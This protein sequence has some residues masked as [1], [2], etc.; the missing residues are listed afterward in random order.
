MAD[1]TE[2]RTSRKKRR[3]M[4]V[5]DEPDINSMLKI[6]LEDN[7][8]GVD[9]FDDPIVALNNYKAGLYDWFN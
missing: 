7:G 1:R 3:I 6:V 8:F 5:D 4:L 2:D 9:S